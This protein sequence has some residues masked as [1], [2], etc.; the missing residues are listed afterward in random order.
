MEVHV[1]NVPEYDYKSTALEP[2]K[3]I[4][5]FL[6]GSFIAGFVLWVFYN[7][8]IVSILGGF[9]SGVCY[10]YIVQLRTVKKRKDVL[11]TQ[12]SVLL[13]IVAISLRTGITLTDA[14]IRAR[15]K[16]EDRYHQNA[17]ILTE[18]D[19]FQKRYED[20]IQPAYIFSDIGR[21]SGI[22]EIMDFA[23]VYSAIEYRSGDEIEIVEKISQIISDKVRT[24]EE[25]QSVITGAKRQARIM[26]Y[27][28]FSVMFIFT[29]F[30][31]NILHPLY[32]TVVGRLTST[33]GL[34][35]YVFSL[36]LVWKYSDIKT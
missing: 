22:E 29:Q 12:F 3:H 4:L 10:I 33:I 13:D 26:L 18:I 14:I 36:Y 6:K 19:I 16:L 31:G 5:T 15:G 32:S 1:V 11:R 27:L 17:D 23:N 25:I 34:V 20:G 7:I 2:H 24:E 21:R 35:V 30:M 9:I 8:F 28:S